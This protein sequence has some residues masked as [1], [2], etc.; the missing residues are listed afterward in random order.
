MKMATAKSGRR[1]MLREDTA[2]AV[3]FLA[4]SLFGF[5]AFVLIPVLFSLVMA[6]TN[7]DLTYREPFAFVG[8]D[9]F[10][11]LLWGE[12]SLQFWKYFLNTL[13]L[14]MGLPVSIAGSLALALLIHRPIRIGWG[15]AGRFWMGLV[16]LAVG[17]VVAWLLAGM[18]LADTAFWV[19]VVALTAGLG[20]W[21]GAVFFRTMFYLPHVTA[22]VAMFILWKNLYNPDFGLINEILRNF[23]GISVRTARSLPAVVS[24]SMEGLIAVA[25]LWAIVRIWRRAISESEGM[26]VW[27]LFRSI[28]LTLAAVMAAGLLAAAL[29]LLPAA[30]RVEL[31]GWLLSVENLWGLSP[32]RIALD[33]R[34]F[35]LGARDA[36]VFM[37]IW[38]AVGGSNM[39]LYL[40][41]LGQVPEE[42]YD[43]A[44]VDGAG[45]WP[46]FR[47][48]T[49]PALAPT[50]FL[51]LVISLAAGFQGG[52]EQARVMT[53]G[54]PAGTTVTLG[55]YIYLTGF[56]E[57]RLG[58]ASAISWLMFAVVFGMT[59]LAWRHGRSVLDERA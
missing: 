13:Y 26:S 1:R 48:V 56:Q 37:G 40:A 59:L 3:A 33:W 42:L 12:E 30:G 57:F 34:F 19:A 35:G 43:A 22:G 52:F 28:L 36:L 8:L 58:M 24:L 44:A 49:W 10:R 46:T 38:M 50:T 53:G 21:A 45:R 7:W 41:G 27:V 17:A 39:L 51:V 5:L 14:M 6:F 4:P 9:N 47:H 54:G 2:A 31:P 18:G 16:C 29:W 11:S 25:M 55:Y 32:E 23:I 20:A 15:R